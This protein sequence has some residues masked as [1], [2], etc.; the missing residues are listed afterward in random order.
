[1]F[2]FVSEKMKTAMCTFKRNN[3]LT[4]LLVALAAITVV[5]CTKEKGGGEEDDKLKEYGIDPDA[6]TYIRTVMTG[7]Y[8][9]ADRTP[10]S[11]DVRG[12]KIKDYFYRH[13]VPED[14]WSWMAEGAEYS[15]IETGVNTSYGISYAQPIKGYGDYGV[16]ISMVNKDG[17]FAKAGVTR[18]WRIDRINGSKVMDLIIGKKFEE[19]IN[20]DRN[21]FTFTDTEGAI[22]EM[23]I[24][25]STFTANCVLASEVYTS[26][27]YPALPKGAKVGYIVYRIFNKALQEELTTSLGKMKEAG[28]T[29]LV[30]DLRINGGGDLDV[31]TELG[32]AL[33]PASA[34]GK[35]FLKI[36]HNEKY[37]KQDKVYS[38]KR[39]SASL[40]LKRLFV[41]GGKSTASASEIIINCLSPYMDVQF[42][43]D[44]THG[45]PN[46]MYVFTYKS[47]KSKNDYDWAF[48]PICFYCV[49]SNGEGNYDNGI[50]PDKLIYDDLYHDWGPGEATLKA[51]LDYIATGSYPEVTYIKKNR[52]PAASGPV[53]KT[54]S[55]SPHYGLAYIKR[56]ETGL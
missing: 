56:G 50:I 48:L 8:F 10:A 20:K 46:G 47:L 36:K 24:A 31:C 4:F 35:S 18:G 25:K 42:V 22:K 51:C 5:G 39:S 54:E 29:D 6:N 37:A 30:L 19:E 26:D 17:P 55:D 13:L 23:E 21:T 3:K 7:P 44:T 9:W 45:K 15:S 52:E 38:I 49:N 12:F 14:R 40:N 16:Y 43:G 53:L 41:I 28:V 32:G 33:A 1:M 11:L 27:N 2:N 34:D